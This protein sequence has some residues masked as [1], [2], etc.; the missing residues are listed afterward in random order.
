MLQS[1]GYLFP[2]F[3]DGPLW[4]K[5]DVKSGAYCFDNYFHLILVIISKIAGK[6]QKMNG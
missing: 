2:I 5:T 4:M 6:H 3:I 1:S